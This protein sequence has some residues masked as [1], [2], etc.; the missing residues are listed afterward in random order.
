LKNFRIKKKKNY[1]KISDFFFLND[2]TKYNF[3]CFIK[4]YGFITLK[5]NIEI[6]PNLTFI[7]NVL[8]NEIFG[9]IHARVECVVCSVGTISP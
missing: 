1:E 6:I 7:T 5:I 8:L 3:I 4:R 9:E 2:K